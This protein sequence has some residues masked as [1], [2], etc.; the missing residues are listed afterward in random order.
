[1]ASGTEPSKITQ[2]SRK[3]LNCASDR[4]PGHSQ[5]A[6]DERQHHGA[7]EGI[8]LDAQLAGFAHVVHLIA[9]GQQAGS[10]VLK[11][12]QSAIER[13]RGHTAQS[14]GVE[15]LE[16]AES[17]RHR[18]V[19]DVGDRVERDELT[20]WTCNMD[21]FQLVRV[22]PLGAFDLRDNLI[23]APLDVETVDVVSAH[24]GSEIVAH[25]LEVEPH[26]CNLVAVN[27]DFRLRL[28]DLRV[29]AQHVE[30]FAG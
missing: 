12:L 30:L 8:T 9:G 11:V 29:D 3:L 6:Q 4:R 20:V 13:Q 24:G 22:E 27:H 25:L 5:E 18:L 21:V 14:D 16:A 2:G 26:G 15:L 1:M 28:V 19:L 7:E 10:F 23:G 17:A